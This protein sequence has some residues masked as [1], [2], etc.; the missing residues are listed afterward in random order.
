MKIGDYVRLKGDI[1]LRH[2]E[3][4]VINHVNKQIVIVNFVWRHHCLGVFACRKKDL[5]TKKLKIKEEK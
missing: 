1:K 5:E 2:G 3:G 4:I